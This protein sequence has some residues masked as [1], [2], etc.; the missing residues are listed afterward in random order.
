MRLKDAFDAWA[1]AALAGS[2]SP[3]T[4]A[5]YKTSI[6]ALDRHGLTTTE[7]ATRARVA[8]IYD[9]RL[10][11]VSVKGA[12][13]DVTALVAVLRYAARR[14]QAVDAIATEIGAL[15]LDEPEPEPPVV[16]TED[17]WRSVRVAAAGVRPWLPL[18]LDLTV[19]AGLRRNEARTLHGEDVLLE[20][21][22]I[23]IVRR[24]TRRL[25]TAQSQREVSACPTLV[26]LLRAAELP[27]EGPIFPARML[28][29]RTPYISML[30]WKRAMRQLAIL[31]GVHTTYGRGRRAFITLAL[32]HGVPQIEVERAVGHVDGTM[33]RKHYYG[34]KRGYASAFDRLRPAI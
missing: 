6:R 4:V 34:W 25:K 31:T 7:D 13:I 24:S 10:R 28:G 27:R 19:L 9:E 33:I 17:E 16:Y 20:E 18:A 2:Y 26:E 15:R 14:D 1:R 3:E 5:R 30:A 29:S 12:N 11:E 8:A 21:R 32:K 23:L 22:V